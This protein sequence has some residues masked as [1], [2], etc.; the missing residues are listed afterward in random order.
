ME[1]PQSQN[2]DPALASRLVALALLEDVLV[3]KRALDHAL[4]GSDEFAAL[5]VRDRAFV[6]MM[7]TT[8]LRRMGQVDDLVSL[9]MDNKGPATPPTLQ[10]ILRLGATQIAFMDVP[11]YA[12]VNC[13]VEMAV[14]AGLSRAKGLVN[15]VLRRVIVEGRDWFIRQD[16]AKL[17]LPAWLMKIWTHD[18][19]ARVAQ[20]IAQ[21]S[22]SEAPLDISVKNEDERAHW[23]QT[24]NATILP[25]GT[26]R[27]T[28]GGNVTE[29]PGFADGMW[30]VQDAAAA[31]P[32]K[33][34]GHI[35]GRTVIDMCA[36]PGGK[37][38]QLAAKGAQVI[39]LDRSMQRLKVL[40]E[41]LQRVRLGDQVKVDA[42][43]ASVWRS[44]APIEMMIIDA[45]CTATGTIRRHPDVLHLK[46]E[47]DMKRM[48]DAQA[49]LLNNAARM[50]APGGVMIYCTCSLQKDEGER[51]VEKLLVAHKNIK[52]DPV[53]P[54]ELGEIKGII[55]T[56]GDVRVL[57]FH[58]ATYGG[59]DG[60]FVSR[61]RKQ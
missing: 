29:L 45:P 19:G 17:N 54:Q 24:L 10:N 34:L 50:L 26:L 47:N 28:A 60:F 58:L 15:A 44:P 8:C 18:Y 41:N 38:M 57:P 5:S 9:A 2:T 30:W 22:L 7:V 16:E 48:M 20:E 55:T 32:V 53:R 37:T 56:E 6:R 3:R 35:K 12:I 43:D 11:D 52:R 59:M 1:N 51:Q 21:A 25:S 46:G 39:A 36:A 42:A 31:L 61:L 33:L 4:A 49:R 14:A 27:R 23:A 40:E 13:G